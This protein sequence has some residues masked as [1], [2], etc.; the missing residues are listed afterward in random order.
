MGALP[1]Y[2]LEII[3]KLKGPLA[4][5]AVGNLLCSRGLVGPYNTA[6]PIALGA[7]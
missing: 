3:L 6:S 4:P 7:C 1:P 5:Y 2:Q